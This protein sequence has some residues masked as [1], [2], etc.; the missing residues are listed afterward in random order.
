MFS[1]VRRMLNLK[2]RMKLLHRRQ[3]QTSSEVHL[4]MDLVLELHLHLVSR[5]KIKITLE[6]LLTHWCQSKS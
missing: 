3:G 2:S 4:H 6:A 1:E 5:V